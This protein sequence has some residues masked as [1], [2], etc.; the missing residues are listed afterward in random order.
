MILKPPKNL[1]HLLGWVVDPTKM[2]QGYFTQPAAVAAP[3]LPS[4]KQ[5][6]THV[7]A[8][9]SATFLHNGE[10]ILRKNVVMTQVGK[11]GKSDIAHVFRNVKTG[12]ITHI[13]ARG[14]VRLT[15]HDRLVVA[16]S[17]SL[18][19]NTNTTHLYHA[20]YHFYNAMNKKYHAW[21]TAK[22]YA[23]LTSGNTVLHDATYSVCNPTD[24]SWQMH[25]KKL[26]LDHE[27]HEGVARD[28]VIRFKNIPILYTPYIS[29]SL[30]H[31][32][33]SGF[34]I[35]KVAYSS[36]NGFRLHQPYYWNISP[37]YDWLLTPGFNSKRGFV[38]DSLFRYLTVSSQGNI[39]I[40]ATPHDKEFK[41]FKAD[42]I[43]DPSVE[44][45]YLSAL[46]AD[47][48]ARG[49]FILMIHLSST[50][51]GMGSLA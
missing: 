49:F 36:H 17:G 37:N 10:T 32:R 24:P 8:D 38:L 20:L 19:L 41:R 18:N 13:K 44:K 33:K 40:N 51:N 23:H 47:S 25:A 1:A 16:E 34:L 28:V 3:L 45:A 35:P 22:N 11:I 7:R 6:I 2:C 4:V 12:K 31:A 5:P 9:G 43:N 21:G 14:H 50:N 46:E 42:A 26:T 48:N 27:K 39:D 30:D 29:F 15:E